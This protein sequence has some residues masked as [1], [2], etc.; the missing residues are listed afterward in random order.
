MVY[1][2]IA[3]IRVLDEKLDRGEFSFQEFVERFGGE[4]PA[5]Q[6]LMD[7]YSQG[8]LDHRGEGVFEVTDAGRR[9]VEAWRTSGKPEAEPWLDSRVYTMLHSS[10][11]AGGRIPDAWRNFL[12]ERGFVDEEGS[13]SPEGYS[14]YETLA[15]AS[16]RP[17]ITKAIAAALVSLPEGP[18]EKKFYSSRFID[19]LEASEL[20]TK[21]VPNGLYAALTRPGRL[22]KRAFRMLNLNANV[23][24][25]LNPIIYGGLEALLR[26]EELDRELREMLGEIGYITAAGSLTLAGRLVIKAWRLIQKPL[27]T[28]PSALSEDELNVMD[29]IVELWEKAKSNPELAPDHK[30]VKEWSEKLGKKYR[31]YT[32]GLA[33]YHL[34]AMGMIAEE[35][36]SKLKRT[37]LRLTRLGEEVYRRSAGKPSTALGSRVLVEADQG[38]GFS[39]EWA[40]RAKDEGLLGT[41][42][43]TKYGLA[44]QKASREAKRSILVTR[45]EAMLLKRLPEKRSMSVEALKKSFPGEEEAIGYALGKLESRG[46]VETLP[47]GRVVITNIGLLVKSAIV[48]APSG[49]ATP[50]NPRI[51]KLLEAVRKLR[52]T[53]DVAKLVKET[54]L[55]LDE[56][57]DALVIARSCKYIGRNSLTGEGEA[58]LE[59]IRLLSE[60]TEAEKPV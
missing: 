3:M 23:P 19:T 44:L 22:L 26:G 1:V 49:V 54:K 24:A 57:K 55:G 35:Y 33:I 56:L 13:L 53:E 45:L 25:L 27:S 12:E 10:V 6:A 46:L 9:L 32:P 4:E 8:L 38:L 30:L 60:Q 14:V 31:Y 15:G 21:S 50:V 16:R 48:A 2:S 17:V 42:G 52:T 11:I 58:L 47:D 7:L 37:V 39:E 34:E 41:G 28:A 20:Y 40:R 18:A 43:P 36:D 5:L 59:A 51:I 29:V